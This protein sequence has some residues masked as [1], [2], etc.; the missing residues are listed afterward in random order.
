LAQL[1]SRDPSDRQDPAVQR[2]TLVSRDLRVS[3]GRTVLEE[4]RAL[5]AP[6][7]NRASREHRA[8]RVRTDQLVPSVHL[9]LPDLP[10]SVEISGPL[11]LLGLLEMLDHPVRLAGLAQLVPKEYAATPVQS[12]PLERLE[13]PVSREL[14][15]RLDLRVSREPMD[16]QGKT[17]RMGLREMLALRDREEK[18]GFKDY[19][20]RQVLQVVREI[21]EAL[22]ILDN[23]V[24]RE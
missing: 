12:D 17:V 18:Q 22:E 23:E 4:R 1:D 9:G 11:V 8:S 6:W 10:D 15:E 21:S 16:S 19:Q 13:Q 14:R 24:V 3:E 5:E 2:A 7:D 20:V